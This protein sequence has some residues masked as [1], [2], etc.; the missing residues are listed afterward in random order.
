MGSHATGVTMYSLI[1]WQK[2]DGM[3]S[4][5]TDAWTSPNH[6]MYVALTV[7]FVHDNGTPPPEWSLIL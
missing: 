1:L 7:H 5:T 6:H 2:F 4:F 3:L